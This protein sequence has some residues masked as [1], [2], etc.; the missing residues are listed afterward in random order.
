MFIDVCSFILLFDFNDSAVCLCMDYDY[1]ELFQVQNAIA[2]IPEGD[3]LNVCA[4]VVWF[5][6]GFIGENDDLF[7][8]QTINIC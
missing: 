2:V 1:D 4:F 3:H 8:K 6:A 7:K 5:G